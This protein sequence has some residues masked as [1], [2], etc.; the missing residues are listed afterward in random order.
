MVIYIYIYTI[1]YIY[2]YK[3][4]NGRKYVLIKHFCIQKRLKLK[5][6]GKYIWWFVYLPT[7]FDFNLFL[8]QKSFIK[9]YFSSVFTFSLYILSDSTHFFLYIYIYISSGTDRYKPLTLSIRPNQSSVLAVP[10]Y[11]IWCPH[12][13]H[14]CKYLP[15]PS[16]REGC[17]TRSILKRSFNRF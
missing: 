2:I 3:G 17:D 15:H 8:I 7:R 5:R 10:L 4:K 11:Y 1:Y 16:A 9:T 13:V 6:V 12:W 14:I